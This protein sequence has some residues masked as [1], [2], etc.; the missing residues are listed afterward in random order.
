MDSWEKFETLTKVLGEKVMLD[1]IENWMSSDMLEEIS[2]D[3]ARDY[4]VDNLEKYEEVWTV[5]I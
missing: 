1:A 2:N 3:I 5:H 4:D